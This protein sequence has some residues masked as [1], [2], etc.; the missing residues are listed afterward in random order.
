MTSDSTISNDIE[1]M[2][3]NWLQEAFEMPTFAQWFRLRFPG[4]DRATL[5][6]LCRRVEREEVG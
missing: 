5:D 2:L 1:C 6:A 4:V 3:T